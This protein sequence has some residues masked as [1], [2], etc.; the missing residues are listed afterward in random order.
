MPVFSYGRSLCID[1]RM[2]VVMGDVVHHVK[3]EE[4]LCGRGNV[5]GGNV[6]GKMSYTPDCLELWSLYERLQFSY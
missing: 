5:R 2:V 1:W 3:R 6:L 4:E